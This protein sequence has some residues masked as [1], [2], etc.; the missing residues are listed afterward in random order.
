MQ[1]VI[2]EASA[3]GYKNYLVAG[4]RSDYFVDIDCIEQ[5]NAMFVNF[6]NADLSYHIPGM[7][8]VMP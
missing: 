6:H 5:D 2:R 8:D 3:Y 1:A 4:I 7:S